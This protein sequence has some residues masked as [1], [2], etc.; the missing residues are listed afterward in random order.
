MWKPW[1]KVGRWEGQKLRVWRWRKRL[2]K[3]G[4]CCSWCREASIHIPMEFEGF[5]HLQASWS[6]ECSR[7]TMLFQPSFLWTR[8]M[9]SICSLHLLL[10]VAILPG[11]SS[12][13]ICQI[14]EANGLYG[15]SPK[16]AWRITREEKTSS[17]PWSSPNCIVVC[18]DSAKRDPKMVATCNGRII[19]PFKQRCK[20]SGKSRPSTVTSCDQFVFR[21]SKFSS[22]FH[23][24][25]EVYCPSWP[26]FA[27]QIYFQLVQP[28]GKFRFNQWTV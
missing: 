18:E 19:G 23:C 21:I 1:Q 9:F 17:E 25:S 7:F 26:G 15:D 6:C 3:S 11:P 4:R 14:S 22:Q 28:M 12:L 2:N 10:F 24:T 13:G 27:G 16:S 20:F 8:V 5:H